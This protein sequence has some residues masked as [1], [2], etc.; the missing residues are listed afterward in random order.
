[1]ILDE[2]AKRLPKDEMLYIGAKSG[3]VFIVTQAE[4]E[5]IVPDE[6]KNRK[7]L[8]HY[9]REAVGVSIIVE[10]EECGKSWFRKEWEKAYET[11]IKCHDYNI[12]YHFYG[13]RKRCGE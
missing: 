8:R 2:V 4:Y 7:V 6:W 1:M 5:G 13:R 9:P 12:F 11:F 10:G 3:Y